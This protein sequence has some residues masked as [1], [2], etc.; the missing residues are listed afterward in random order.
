VQ[1][2]ALESIRETPGRVPDR[3][4]EQRALERAARESLAFD[5]NERIGA[6]LNDRVIGHIFGSALTLASI[7]GRHQLDRGITERLHDVI[8]ELDEAVREI[9]STVF[10]RLGHNRTA[11]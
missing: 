10:A 3:V 5:E 1:P 11:T 2:R 7:V 4:T 6:D 9:R 8:D